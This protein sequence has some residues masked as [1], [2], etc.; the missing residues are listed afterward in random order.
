MLTAMVAI[1]FLKFNNYE[2]DHVTYEV[3]NTSTL[4]GGTTANLQPG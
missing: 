1:D 4:I 3:R 2:P